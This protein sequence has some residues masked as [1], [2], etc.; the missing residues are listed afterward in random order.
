MSAKPYPFESTDLGLIGTNLNKVSEFMTLFGQS[1]F[2]YPNFA[3]I[4][5]VGSSLYKFR[6][7]LVF[8]ELKE[9][10]KAFGYDLSKE[11]MVACED[12]EIDVIEFADGIGDLLVVIY[13]TLLAFGTSG[14]SSSFRSASNYDIV[15]QAMVDHEQHDNCIK[16]N[17]IKNSFFILASIERIAKLI[18]EVNAITPEY[19]TKF[20]AGDIATADTAAAGTAIDATETEL[21]AAENTYARVRKAMNITNI[22][23][24]NETSSR[25]VLLITSMFDEMLA[26]A[27]MLAVYAGIDANVIFDLVHMSNMSKLCSS[28]QNAIETIAENYTNH[29]VYKNVKYKPVGSSGYHMVYNDLGNGQYKVL[30]SKSFKQPEI[31]RYL[32]AIGGI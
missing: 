7:S 16:F 18:N 32:N 25:F 10:A 27:Y 13:G 20:N 1:V 14:R 22:M 30:K 8:E 29:A 9:T 4:M 19:V 31:V 26:H 5:N 12:N 23:D 28:E 15:K 2:Y 24:T 17:I 6:M 11:Q 21:N 3:E